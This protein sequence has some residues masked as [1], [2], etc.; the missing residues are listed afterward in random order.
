[1]QTEPHSREVA[2]KLTGKAVR[3]QPA[4]PACFA[5][6]SGR[7]DCAFVMVIQVSDV[8]A[9]QSKLLLTP[10]QPD[11]NGALPASKVLFF[12]DVS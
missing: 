4:F 5:A 12:I 6:L 2:G 7:I 11:N 9:S 1:M 8:V 3:P 10:A